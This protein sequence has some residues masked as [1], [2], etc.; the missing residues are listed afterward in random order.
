LNLGLLVEAEEGLSWPAWRHIARTAES[1]GFES[2]WISDHLLSPWSDSRHGLDAWVALTQAFDQT[3][4]LRLGALVSP[5]M[6]REPALL[7]RMAEALDDLSPGRLVV[8]LGLGWNA[9]EHTSFGIAFPPAAQRA[10]RLADGIQL[11]R[12]MLAGRDVPILI[13][14]MGSKWTLPLVARCA[15]EWN[16]TTASV[17]VY[18]ERSQEVARLCQQVGRD[19][20]TIRRSV[21]VGC[22]V[23]RDTG[24]VLDR[25]RRI[26]TCVPPLAG[27]DPRAVPEAARAMGWVAGTC[28]TAVTV[29]RAL[30]EAGVDRAILGYYDF[31]DTS[32]LEL[33]AAEVLPRV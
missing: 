17:E 13:G 29:L 33:I 22:L 25:A 5:I 32:M 4:R 14:G 8:G 15:D 18:R 7:A 10:Q 26:Q 24:D 27:I 31:A 28:E 3:R 1:L 19:P 6:F 16:L 21:A 12:R 20:A 9:R 23:G 30:V 11:L 2:L